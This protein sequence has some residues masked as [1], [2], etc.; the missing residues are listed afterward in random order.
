[1]DQRVGVA[2]STQQN[3]IYL[4]G[5]WS[6]LII[7]RTLPSNGQ[8]LRTLFYNTCQV[9]KSVKD[10]ATL[11]IKEVD[12]FWRKA[13]IPTMPV[14]HCVDKL[15]KLYQEWSELQESASRPSATQKEKE[16]AFRSSLGDLFDVAHE[17]AL[18]NMKEERKQFL[19]LQREKGRQRREKRLA[20]LQ[21]ARLGNSNTSKGW[22]SYLIYYFRYKIITCNFAHYYTTDTL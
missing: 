4:I 1:M 21:S 7:S 15:E 6:H 11:T 13:R 14:H 9:G 17:N 2:G 12:I 10:A 3:K 18:I 20:V 19:L 22:F 5:H 8:V 16:E